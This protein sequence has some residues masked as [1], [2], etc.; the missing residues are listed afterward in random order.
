M[1]LPNFKMWNENEDSLEEFPRM[2]GLASK[3]GK[4]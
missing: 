1:C 3:F 4:G 2:A